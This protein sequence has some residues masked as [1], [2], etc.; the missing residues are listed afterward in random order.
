[1]RGNFGEIISASIEWTKTVLFRP[2]RFKKWIFLYII[3]SIAFQ[4]QGGCNFNTNLK[5]R[6]L[7]IK[8]P[9]QTEKAG[10]KNESF[11]AENSHD[12]P[13]KKKTTYMI[14][15]FATLLAILIMGLF[16]VMEWLYSIFSFV[17]I[18]SVAGNDASIKKPFLRNRPIGNS[19]FA[20]NVIY[21]LVFLGILAIVVKLGYDSL[22]VLGVFAKD[23]SV[24]FGAMAAALLPN[25][26]TCVCLF[27]A[28][29]LISL[30]VS[31]YALV[32]MYKERLPILKAM[33]P[34]FSL[35]LSDVGAFIKYLF[36]KIGLV[37]AIAIISSVL[38]F[39]IL[40]AL[41]VPGAIIVIIAALIYKIIPGFIQPFYVVVML[42]VG[43]PLIV[44]VLFLVNAVFV[45]FPVFLKTF[46]LK[47]IAR[48][49]EKYNLFRLTE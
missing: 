48:L 44:A 27:L 7:G 30:F 22:S 2:V 28:S 19:Y 15:F 37:I 14:A 31:D 35:L 49:D 46:N 41:F 29:W 4:M 40:L 33:E 9:A 3:A 6:N 42:L 16:L 20:W 11:Y 26:I 21:T 13:I 17:F 5:P 39:A 43:V 10:V 34:S 36:V 45:P 47:F 18:E 8:R 1:M 23:A 38:F 24:S 12:D 32:V 25:I